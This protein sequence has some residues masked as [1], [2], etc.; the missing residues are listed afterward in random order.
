MPE[1][2]VLPDFA[3][4][5]DQAIKGLDNPE[6]ATA[7]TQA[8]LKE[9]RNS[10]EP[11]ISTPGEKH[12][13]L[14]R[15]ICRD[16]TWYR[17]AEVKELTGA[18]EEAIAAAGSSSYKVFDTLLL[19]G[20]R[21]VGN[22]TMNRKLAAELLIGDR[23]LLVMAVRRATFGDTVEF[24]ELPCPYCK[25]LIDLTVPLGAIPFTHLA[26]PEQTEFEVLCATAPWH[27]SG[28]PPARTRPPSSPSRT[29]TAPS[30]TQKSSTAASCASARATGR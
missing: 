25:E 22:E 28:C 11:V 9:D 20:V 4:F 26:D 29:E 17:E 5:G 12:V 10:G 19:R 13:T 27:S 2:V 6:A 21:T 30:R 18:D 1:P 16:G 14:E 8:L 7:A 24:T 3:S 23:E 15:G